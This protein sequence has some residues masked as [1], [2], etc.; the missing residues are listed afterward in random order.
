MRG[1]G[2]L[3][4]FGFS[5]RNLQQKVSFLLETQGEALGEGMAAHRPEVSHKTLSG[6]GQGAIVAQ[7]LCFRGLVVLIVAAQGER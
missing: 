2:G 1:G 3:L 5:V 6:Q 4:A 7:G